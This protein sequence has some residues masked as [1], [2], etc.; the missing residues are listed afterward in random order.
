MS[1]SVIG[2]LRANLGMDSA[3][4]ERGARRAR[5]ASDELRSRLGR[6]TA[7]AAG[8]TAALT[9]MVGSSASAA[10]EIS[11][12]AS[13][14]NTTPENLQRWASATSTV[15][16]NQERLA[17]ILKDVNDRVGDFLST[18]GGEMADFFENIAPRVGVT[19]EM[20]RDLSG[21]EALQLYV[22]TLQ[23]AG[24][25]QQRMTFYMEALANDA[26][27]LIP[28]LRDNGVELER[29]AQASD[30]FGLRLTNGQVE[31]LNRTSDAF[32]QLLEVMGGLRDQ[33]AARL[34]PAFNAITEAFLRSAQE[35]G[36]LS[37]VFEVLLDNVEGLTVAMAGFATL[38]AGQIV[39]NMARV[40]GVAGA[41]A[42]SLGLVRSAFLLM[43]GPV[44]IAVGLVGA[45]LV[46]WNRLKDLNENLPP[47][48][49]DVRE[50][51]DL[52]NVALGNYQTGA[53]GSGAEAIAYA[54][55]LETTARAALAAAEAQIAFNEA[56]LQGIDRQALEVMSQQPGWESNPMRGVL[57][58]LDEQQARAAELR[59]TLE[60]ASRTLNSLRIEAA[61]ASHA[62]GELV[63]DT[64][65]LDDAT[66]DVVETVASVTDELGNMG[67]GA[68]RAAADVDDLTDSLE[69]ANDRSARLAD[70]FSSTASEIIRGASSAREA[71]GRLLDQLADMALQ[72]AFQPLFGS[73]FGGGGNFLG[74]LFGGFR[75]AGGPVSS[76]RAYVVGEEGPEL[77]MP[78]SSGSIVPNGAMGGSVSV[79]MPISID[80]RGAERGVA[81]D[82]DRSL[83]SMMP[84]LQRY[85]VDTVQNAQ[86]RGKL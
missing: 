29:L 57:E 55:N 83:R 15:G 67:G 31:A 33:I 4:F 86:K 74:G 21:P 8:V 44:G 77:F 51:Q 39:V 10:N 61:T 18:G 42:T 84:E 56:R 38:M 30:R 45:A 23:Q 1:Q 20:F 9:A 59:L 46:A 54:Q 14:A 68:G 7:V 80:A 62:L 49:D 64:T 47:G 48:I 28:L 53:R 17:D 40:T 41:L 78:S 60:N 66:A 58:G 22:S 65:A 79:S 25:G 52:L 43:T 70:M 69:D 6:I 35:G 24:L 32:G 37:R 11:R 3:Q 76:G 36:T 13:I 5:G 63:F 50:A 19:A 81:T 73:L 71:V 27:L 75:A 12:L 72:A 16:I 2:A 85:I 26:T 82:I 34:A